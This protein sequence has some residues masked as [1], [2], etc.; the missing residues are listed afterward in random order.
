M[1]VPSRLVVAG[2][3]GRGAILL[4]QRQWSQAGHS[5]CSLPQRLQRERKPNNLSDTVKELF[6][7]VPGNVDPMLN[8]RLVGCRR[9]AVV[10]NSGNLKD[11]SYGPE[12]DSHDFVLR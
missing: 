8:K 9:C 6:R 7:L 3:G 11:S 4:S 1:L 2:F 10:G 12:I 5:L